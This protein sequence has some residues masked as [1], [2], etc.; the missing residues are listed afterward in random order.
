MADSKIQFKIGTIE[1][2]SE[3]DPTWVGAQLDK[4]LKQIP[5]LIKVSP[6]EPVHSQATPVLKHLNPAGTSGKPSNL[7]LFLKQHVQGTNATK[8]FLTAAAFLQVNG[9][10]RLSTGDVTKAL[11]AAN[12]SKLRNASENLNSNV[13]KGLCEKVDGQFFVTTAGLATV[14]LE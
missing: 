10:S 3:G 6:P 11:T 7:A 9:K 4:V 1:F 13:G 12:Q 2:S 5:E 14:G 8:T